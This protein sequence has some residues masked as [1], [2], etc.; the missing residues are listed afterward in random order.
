MVAFRELSALSTRLSGHKGCRDQPGVVPA[1]VHQTAEQAVL[2]RWEKGLG[3]PMKGKPSLF[4]LM[5]KNN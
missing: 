5:F 2:D 4:G 3:C 1:S